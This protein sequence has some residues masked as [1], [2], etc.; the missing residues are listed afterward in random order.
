MAEQALSQSLRS[1]GLPDIIERVLE[2]GIVLVGDIKVN[3]CDIELLTIKIRLLIASVETA[4]KLGID[5]W[6]NDFDLSS[7]AK[8]I[9]EENRALKERLE[10]LEAKLK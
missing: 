7:K 4:Q 6:K 5:W 9:F 3:L 8:E 10:K 1:E 2:K